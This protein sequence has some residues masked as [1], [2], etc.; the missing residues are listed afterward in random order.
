MQCSAE[1]GHV[2]GVFEIGLSEDATAPVGGALCVCVCYVLCVMCYMLCAMC[3][4]KC[5]CMCMCM[6]YVLCVYVYV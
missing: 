5:M 2:G 6:C 4:C 1:Q 3:V